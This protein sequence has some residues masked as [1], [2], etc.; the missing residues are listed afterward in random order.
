MKSSNILILVILMV[1]ILLIYINDSNNHSNIKLDLNEISK[2]HEKKDKKK[3][4]RFN[5]NI[6]YNTYKKDSVELNNVSEK[7]NSIKNSTLC[8]PQSRSN[9]IMKN[10]SFLNKYELDDEPW[11]SSFGKPLYTKSEH[12]IFVEKMQKN[13]QDYNKCLGDMLKYQ[14]DNNIVIKTDITIDPFN[15]Q[16]FNNKN[17]GKTIKD[18]Y[19]EQVAGPQ[20]VSR[21]IIRNT[22]NETYY[23]DEPLINNEKIKGYDELKTNYRSNKFNNEF[24][25]NEFI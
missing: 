13:M 3:K 25:I 11:D 14:T 17:K 2:F 5:K 10:D 6:E 21:K 4:V 7:N 9:N 1:T 12:K 16:K 24:D 8:Y 15:S 19:D 20:V 18:I 22:D 23:E